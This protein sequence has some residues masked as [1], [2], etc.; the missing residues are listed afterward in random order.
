MF[1]ARKLVLSMGETTY[2]CGLAIEIARGE[3]VPPVDLG[4]QMWNQIEVRPLMRG[5]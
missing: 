2:K 3:E 1:L 4:C 5:M